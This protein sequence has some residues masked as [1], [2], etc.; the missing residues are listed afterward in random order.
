MSDIALRTPHRVGKY[1]VDVAVM[2]EM[3]ATELAVRSGAVYL[4]DEITRSARL[5]AH[6]RP[7]PGYSQNPSVRKPSCHQPPWPSHC[8]LSSC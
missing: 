3:A 2:D 4:V 7:S 5:S 6:A 8:C 1:G